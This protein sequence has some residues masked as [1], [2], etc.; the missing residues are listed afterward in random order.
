MQITQG[1]VVLSVVVA[2]ELVR[3]LAL[4]RQQRAG[5]AASSADRRAAEPGRRSGGMTVRDAPADAS[6][7]TRRR[8]DR[9]ARSTSAPPRG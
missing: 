4:A 5:R 6:A 8:A 7:P 2:Y 9:A 3:R 1:V